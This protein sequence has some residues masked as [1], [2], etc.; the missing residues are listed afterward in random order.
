MATPIHT[1]REETKPHEP[2]KTRPG[3]K[4]GAR[5]PHQKK[6]PQRGLGV[7]QLERLRLQ[8]K[9]NKITEMSPPHHFIQSHSPTFLLDNTLTNFPL[10]FP[11]AAPVM[12]AT[13]SGGGGGVL[14]FDHQGLVVQ[15]I[16]NHGGFLAGGEPYSHGGGVLIG[17]SS[18]EASRELSS[19]PKLPPPS[20]PPSCDS[21]H[22]DICFKKKR[23]NFSNLMKEKNI[24]IAAAETPPL[25]A[26]GFDFLGLS[27][28]NST[29][30]LN[31]STVVNH[32]ANPDFGFSFNFNFNQGRSGGN[33][34]S[35]SGGGG[36]NGEG[37]SRLM[38]YEFFP[39]KNCRG[40]E[41]EEL[42]MP[43]EELS[44]FGE[45]NE[46][47]E[48]V[49][50]VDHGEGSCITTSCNDIINGGTRNST[51]LDLSLKLSF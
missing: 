47:E 44:L 7:A 16:G 38:E 34:G 28:T 15:R 49:L 10:Q 20:L 14:G 9:W 30:E 25:A 22:C 41:I 12:V 19:I 23:V 11:A 21:D 17:N 35:G 1:G 37:S 32:H 40:T 18:V 33:S 36:G 8:D 46:E 2:P 29:A 5:N 4:T 27:T 50:A 42:K 3:R 31:N 6:P 45:E 43:K 24:N 26:A 39:R 48:E 51:A 13:D